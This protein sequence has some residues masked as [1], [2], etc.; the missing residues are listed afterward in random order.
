MEFKK[1]KDIKDDYLRK[2]KNNQIVHER[3]IVKE[4]EILHNQKKKIIKKFKRYVNIKIY[5]K[6][7]SVCKNEYA[8]G[9]VFLL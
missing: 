5:N 1:V 8:C 4:D 9:F 3:V 6:N 7:K 2:V